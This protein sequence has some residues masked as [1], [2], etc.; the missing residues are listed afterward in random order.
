MLLA[1]IQKAEIRSAVQHSCDVDVLMESNGH[2]GRVQ[3]ITEL[4]LH[5]FVTDN[6]YR[7]VKYDFASRF[8]VRLFQ[9]LHE[10]TIRKYFSE[11]D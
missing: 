1:L 5:G 7:Q 3:H 11:A 9:Q 2:R 8:V 6:T 4:V 10:L